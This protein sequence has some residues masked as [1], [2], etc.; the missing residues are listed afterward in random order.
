MSRTYTHSCDKVYCDCP[1]S[2]WQ[3]VIPTTTAAPFPNY[4]YPYP[5][6]TMPE[7]ELLPYITAPPVGTT[8]NNFRTVVFKEDLEVL[9]SEVKELRRE[10]ES[11][12]REVRILR[13]TR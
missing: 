7:A 11:L 5:T 4:P 9:M 3:P 10:V 8:E 13:K 12:R 1:Q 2:M 6:H